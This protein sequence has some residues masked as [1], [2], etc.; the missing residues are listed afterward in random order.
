[1][2]QA[3]AETLVR[4]RYHAFNNRD[5]EGARLSIAARTFEPESG[6]IDKLVRFR[7]C[8]TRLGSGNDITSFLPTD[9]SEEFIAHVYAF[10]FHL[11]TDF[12]SDIAGPSRFTA[13][14][15]GQHRL[16]DVTAVLVH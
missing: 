8:R 4:R 3:E 15:T 10:G 5:L 13:S 2:H 12:D 7:W 14:P 11:G 9:G 16:E 1:M 6:L